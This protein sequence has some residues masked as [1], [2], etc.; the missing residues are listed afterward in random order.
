[1]SFLEIPAIALTLPVGPRD[2]AQ[3]SP[4]APLVLVEYGDFECPHCGRAYPIVKALRARIGDDLGFVHRNLPLTNVH[5]HAQRAAETAE[6]AALHDR[7]WPMHDW[8][9]EHQDRLEERHLLGAAR[10]LGLDP[11]GLRR[12]WDTHALIPRV[13]ED[14]KSALD[15]GVA[16]T[17]GFFINGRRHEGAW[18]VDAL[19][20]A[21]DA[22]RALPR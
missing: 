19:A 12:A 2:H 20:A 18:G 9:Y 6:W 13:K 16:G 21:L 7:F 1:V 22:A 15:S 11:D 14:L 17:P 10:E 8:L 3:G 5:P 4:S